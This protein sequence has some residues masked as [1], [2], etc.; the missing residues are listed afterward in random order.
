MTRYFFSIDEFSQRPRFTLQS[1]DGFKVTRDTVD[2]LWKTLFEELQGTG[3]DGIMALEGAMDGMTFVGLSLGPIINMVERLPG[4]FRCKDYKFKYF[5][6]DETEIQ[7]PRINPTG[8][9]RTEPY[10]REL[11]AEY[12][13]SVALSE[14]AGQKSK[15][16]VEKAKFAKRTSYTPGSGPL[17]G[18]GGAITSLAESMQY[19]QAKKI[20]MQTIDVK[21]SAIHGWGLF[22]KR[23]IHKGEMII[24]YVGEKI[25]VELCDAREAY[26]DGRNIGSY[27]FRI[28]DRYAVDATLNG[29]KARFVNHSCE[30][31]CYS[32]VVVAEGEGHIMIF[33]LKEVQPFQELVYDYKFPMEED[34]VRV[35][36]KCGAPS[37]TGYMN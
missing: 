3:F 18:S 17:V 1:S 9:A 12:Q 11:L 10:S 31:N 13:E 30:P 35:E 32:R 25:R 22:A 2:A 36:C 6:P 24:E 27:M 5:I 28:D 7:G 34:G 8:C 33:A 23:L 37:C 21:H 20:V 15:S 4:A 16:Q 14:S 29:G 19:R 26:Y